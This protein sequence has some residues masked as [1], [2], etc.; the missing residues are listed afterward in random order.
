MCISVENHPERNAMARRQHF[1][2]RDLQ[3]RFQGS[4]DEM[5]R[6]FL[7]GRFGWYKNVRFLVQ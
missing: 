7:G 4:P 5:L 3:L 1:K 6:H 2:A